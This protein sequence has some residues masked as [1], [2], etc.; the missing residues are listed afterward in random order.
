MQTY[1]RAAVLIDLT[2]LQTPLPTMVRSGISHAAVVISTKLF[3]TA[4]VCRS[5]DRGINLQ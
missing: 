1:V 5:R 4:G 2:L 3:D